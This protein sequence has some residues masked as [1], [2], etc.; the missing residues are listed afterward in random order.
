MRISVHICVLLIDG[1]CAIN[2]EYHLDDG[3]W[4]RLR[5]DSGE[6]DELGLVVLGMFSRFCGEF[7]CYFIQESL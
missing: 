1:L 4:K 7:E 6:A 3:S 5:M 2:H